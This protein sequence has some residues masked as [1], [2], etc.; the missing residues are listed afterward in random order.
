MHLMS[1]CVF[2]VVFMTNLKQ[3]SCSQIIGHIIKLW[4]LF[5]FKTL[6]FRHKT[7]MCAMVDMVKGVT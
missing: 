6:T 4:S 7:Y 3:T 2:N 1:S 5:I